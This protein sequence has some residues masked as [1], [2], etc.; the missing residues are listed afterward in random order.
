MPT[1]HVVCR[2]ETIVED[3]AEALALA[4]RSK[5]RLL[6]EIAAAGS[7]VGG[8]IPSAQV[9]EVPSIEAPEDVQVAFDSEVLGLG[10][11]DFTRAA[12]GVLELPEP[13]RHRLL[14]LVRGRTSEVE[15]AR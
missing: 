7:L 6:D 3:R 2:T 13:T 15:A 12:D 1:F 5:A 8:E 11:A 10:P 9:F 4:A 14:D